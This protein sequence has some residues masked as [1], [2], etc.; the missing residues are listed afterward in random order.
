MV[1]ILCTRVALVGAFGAS[2]M[3]ALEF[4]EMG[5]DGEFVNAGKKSVRF[6][7]HLTCWCCRVQEGYRAV[8]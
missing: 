4:D 7:L 6:V 1:Y 3:D 2:K 8:Y 5:M